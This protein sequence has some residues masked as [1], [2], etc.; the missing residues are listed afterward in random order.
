MKGF[1]YLKNSLNVN[2]NRKL[3]QK[4]S[5][6]FTFALFPHV[7]RLLFWLHQGS[8]ELYFPFKTG[9]QTS[10]VMPNHK[11]LAVANPVSSTITLKCCPSVK[12]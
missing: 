8:L 6:K 10:K 9:P 7:K 11:K 1:I 12:H 2:K 4:I 5:M 3:Y